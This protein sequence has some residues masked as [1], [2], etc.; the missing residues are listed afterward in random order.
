MARTTRFKD[1]TGQRFGKYVVLSHVANQKW[2]CRCD[3]GT[4]KVIISHNLI[5]G[6]ASMC[7][8]CY[9]KDRIIDLTGQRI[10]KWTVIRLDRPG[11]WL[12]RCDCGT[13][14]VCA[15]NNLRSGTSTQCEKCRLV[16]SHKPKHG[17]CPDGKCSITYRVWV[18]VKQRC[19]TQFSPYGGNGICICH[20]WKSDF[21]NFLTSMGERPSLDVSIDRANKDE[22]TRHYSCGNC[23][24]CREKG[25]V[26]HCRWATQA[27]QMRNVSTNRWL[28]HNGQTLIIT[29]WSKVTGLPAHIITSRID[30]HGWSVEKALDTPVRKRK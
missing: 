23:D 13:E 25:W 26:F 3:C 27:E 17:H 6:Q 14:S 7:R 30:K 8:A 12:C 18:S 20:G 21:N 10:G 5:T 2:N 22:S 9:H 1:I 16:E 29:D 24:E 19:G 15:R 28:T 4:E 11:F